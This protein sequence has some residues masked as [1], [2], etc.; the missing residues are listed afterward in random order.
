[1][2]LKKL[3][4]SLLFGLLGSSVNVYGQVSFVPDST[5]GVNGISRPITHSN[6]SMPT[7]ALWIH[8][9]LG[10]ALQDD[11]KIVLAGTSNFHSYIE[12]VRLNPD[13]SLDTSFNQTG[14]AT[15]APNP[16]G[17]WIFTDVKVM[18]DGKILIGYTSQNLFNSR[19]TLLRLLPNGAVDAS[20]GNAGKIDIGMTLI[21]DATWLYSIALQTD[22][23]IL[24]NCLATTSSASQKYI[25][26]RI[27]TNGTL[28]TSFGINGL[29]RCPYLPGENRHVIA[30]TICLQNDG[31]ILATG[32]IPTDGINADTMFILRYNTNG[33]PDATYGINGIVKTSGTFVPGAM[34]IDATDHA[35][36]IGIGSVNTYNDTFYLMKF[37]PTGPIVSSFGVGGTLTVNAKLAIWNAHEQ[38]TFAGRLALQPDGKILVAGNSDTSST[39]LFRLCRLLPDGQ[40]DATFAPNGTITV[41]RGVRDYCS[42]LLIQPDGKILLTGFYRTGEGS[43]DTARVLAMRFCD[44]ISALNIA[45]GTD[46]NQD[47]TNIYP[48]PLVNGGN[49]TIEYNNSG[50]SRTIEFCLTNITG[51]Q[52]GKGRL[53]MKKGQGSENITLPNKLITGTYILCIYDGPNL[54]KYQKIMVNE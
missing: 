45:I 34:D 17:T 53:Y 38:L 36:V 31:K 22:G 10:S 6:L 4:L 46:Q 5:F 18:S 30:N 26:A 47:V 16:G 25:I 35:Y 24:A 39:S 19:S 3:L 41:N 33:T 40:M 37:S 23:K 8:E 13:G 49:F 27:K 20:F 14:F 44:S 29:A 50:G 1:M 51:Q 32:I 21:G 48:N 11:G 42:N 43:F 15:Y 28:D 2:R 9:M 54:L 12:V 7:S 52:V